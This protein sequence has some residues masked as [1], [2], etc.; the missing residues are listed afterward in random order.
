MEHVLIWFYM[1]GNW[2]AHD[3]DHEDHDGHNNRW[4]NLRELTHKQNLENRKPRDKLRGVYWRKDVEKWQAAIKHN[5]RYIHLGVY[6]DLADAIHVR[7]AAERLLF[8]HSP[9]C[10]SQ[11]S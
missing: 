11:S 1:T 4:S 5:Y 9:L 3:I 8:T 7:Q 2:P 10:P 6:D